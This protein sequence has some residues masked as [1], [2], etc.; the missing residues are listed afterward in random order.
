VI[1]ATDGTVIV[2]VAVVVVGVVVVVVVGPVGVVDTVTVVE[3]AGEAAGTGGGGS[4]VGVAPPLLV[5]GAT[6]VETGRAGVVVGVGP[7]RVGALVAVAAPVIGGRRLSGNSN[8]ADGF[9]D[10]SPELAEALA[11][12]WR[13]GPADGL[14]GAVVGA[15]PGRAFVATKRVRPPSDGGVSFCT[16][17]DINESHECGR[18]DDDQQNGEHAARQSVSWIMATICRPLPRWSRPHEPLYTRLF[19]T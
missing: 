10:A 18:R 12:G 16:K 5:V 1:V 13:A 9:V 2:S 17:P 6:G 4:V 14:V 3:G 8:G 11:A 15:V 19:Q 7:G